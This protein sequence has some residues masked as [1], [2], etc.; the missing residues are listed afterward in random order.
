M[1]VII[2]DVAFKGTE[3]ANHNITVASMIDLVEPMS[4]NNFFFCS[5]FKRFPVGKGC[6]PNSLV[7]TTFRAILSLVEEVDDLVLP[8]FCKNILQFRMTRILKML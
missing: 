6:S 8:T 7:R 1:L 4:L 2:F 5:L 3:D